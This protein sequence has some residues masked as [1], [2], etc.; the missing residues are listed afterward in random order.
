MAEPGDE[1]PDGSLS[2]GRSL[3]HPSSLGHGGSGSAR[4]YDLGVSWLSAESS[5]RNSCRIWMKARSGC[6]EPWRP[7]P[8]RRRAPRVADRARQ[9]LASFPEVP[10]GGQSDRASGRWHRHHRLF[11]YG[12]LRRSAAEGKMAAGIPSGQRAADRGHGPRVGENSGS[13]LGL[14]ATHLRQSGRS[15]ERREGR[16]GGEDLWRRSENAGSE[17]R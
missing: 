7:V 8:D 5:A 11:Q 4:A 17:G 14:L 10:P 16:A 9:I 12:I 6:A 1:V 2:E 13:D 15:G 3:G